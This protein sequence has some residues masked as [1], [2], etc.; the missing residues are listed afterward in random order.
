MKMIIRILTGLATILILLISSNVSATEYF[1]GFINKKIEKESNSKKDKDTTKNDKTSDLYNKLFK[2]KHA[3][4]KGL[5]NIHKIDGQL[6]FEI[7]VSLFGKDLLMGSTVSETSDNGNV[8]VG[9]KPT[10]PLLVNFTM[11]NDKVLLNKI[12]RNSIAPSSDTNIVR[13]I[14]KNSIGAILSLFKIETYNPDSS[15]VV[16]NT[17]DLFL[18]ERSDITPFDRASPNASLGDRNPIFQKERSFITDFKSF[19]D[20]ISVKSSLSYNITITGRDRRVLY[21]DK[22]YTV[23]V[24]RSFLLLDE[25][26]YNY[27]IADYRIG[28]FSSG[29]M[30]YSDDGNKAEELYFAHRWRIEPS[31]V[32]AYKRGEKVDPVKQIIFYVDKDFPEWWKPHIKRAIERWNDAF[33]RIGFKNVVSA[34]DYPTDDPNFDPDNIKYSCV[35]YSPVEVENAMGPSWVDPRSGEIINASVYV[36]HDVVKLINKWLFVQTSPV[37]VRVRKTVIPKEILGDALEYVLSHEV[38]HCLGFMHNMGAS[39]VI[40]VDSL[41]SPAFTAKYGTTTSIMDYAR[42]N[43]VAQPGDFERGVKLTPPKLG[44]Y[45]YYLVEWLYTPL[46]INDPFAEREVLSKWISE[47]SGDK[48]YRYGK[49]QLFGSCDPTSQM[50]DLGDDPVRASEYGIKNLKYIMD[51]LNEWLEGQ[52]NDYTYRTE[53]YKE[54]LNQYSRYLGHVFTNIGGIIVNE[55]KVGDKLPHFEIVSRE[56]QSTSLQFLLDQIYDLDWLDN[57]AFLRNLPLQT[58]YK[59][60]IRN[61][62]AKLIVSSGKRVHFGSTKT[63]DPYTTK[64]CLTDL[65]KRVFKSLDSRN[66][67]SNTDIVLQKAFVDEMIKVAEIDKK[68][69]NMMANLI[70]EDLDI[71]QIRTKYEESPPK[72]FELWVLINYDLGDVEKNIFYE[73]LL[74][75]GKALKRRINSCTEEAKLHYQLLLKSIEKSKK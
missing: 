56:R 8:T 63:N 18:S 25:E 4:S 71:E 39:A 23:S 32:S 38:G 48:F 66:T 73:F 12:I 11:E 15:S 6:Y 16:V 60:N 3:E 36:Y 55:K 70:A 54:I 62:L 72:G 37:D 75:T 33:E 65:Y 35:R 69:S 51:N 13:A 49:Q 20:N 26:P 24:T 59:D 31:D 17:T 40:P 42:F 44:V 5:I 2:E 58:S 9:S 21:T 34:R 45:D 43:Y 19:E 46:F 41:R 61:Q 30:M 57:K 47:K 74:K 7:P 53:I 50:E 14:E 1:G 28:I 64:E 29:R 27:R 52:D 10:T 22:P 67:P 68:P